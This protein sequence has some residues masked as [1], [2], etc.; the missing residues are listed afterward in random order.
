MQVGSDPPDGRFFTMQSINP[1]TVRIHSLNGSF[2]DTT[3]T[4]FDGDG[5]IGYD[6]FVDALVEMYS[7]AVVTNYIHMLRAGHFR[8]VMMRWGY[9]SYLSA[10]SV[11]ATHTP[12]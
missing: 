5:K 9:L 3:A 2:P 11:E 8:D 1:T 7:S 4:L 12:S 6:E 10:D